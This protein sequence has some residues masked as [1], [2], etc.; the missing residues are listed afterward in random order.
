MAKSVEISAKTMELAIEKGAL[1]LGVAQEDVTVE[2]LESSKA[3]FLG[4]GAKPA[5]YLVSVIGS[6]E[7]EKKVE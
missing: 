7:P 1:E 3:G 4:I 2:L 6:D 5:K